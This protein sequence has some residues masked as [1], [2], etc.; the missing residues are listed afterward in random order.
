[1]AMDGQS[2][3]RLD[4][5]R[6]VESLRN[7]VPNRY[8][9]RLL[10][11][12]QP[13]VEERFEALLGALESESQPDHVNGMFVSGGFGTGKSHFLIHLEEAALELGFV[14]SKV[15][16]SKETPLFDLDKVF[17]SAVFHARV[18]GR[19]GLLIENLD[20]PEKLDTAGFE[21]FYGW[22]AT[23]TFRGQL[24]GIF[25]AGLELFV[26]SETSAGLKSRLEAFWGGD[27]LAPTQVKRGL[28]QIGRGQA[29]AFRAPRIA[30]LPPQRLRFL[31]RMIT[32]AGYRGWLVLLDELELIE[33][34]TPLQRGRAYA[35]LTRWFGAG[36]SSSN[37]G[38]VV[39][40]AVSD[41]FVY[42]TISPRGMKKDADN[43]PPKL[44][45]KPRYEGMV[46]DVETG[47]ELLQKHCFPL[48]APSVKE[49]QTVMKRLRQL[50]ATA[51]DW[52]PPDA[53]RESHA[54]GEQ[55]KMRYRIRAAINDWDLERLRERDR[56]I[57]VTLA[58]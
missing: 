2:S 46:P 5:R 50:Y 51:Y 13:G 14:C 23:K 3:G 10:G 22:T 8:A 6:A 15:S 43:L 37:F 38:L 55:S 44:A 18:P 24:N 40:G 1:M 33:R 16:I 31:V 27:K 42:T 4:A 49:V 9:V 30:D 54:V 57:D 41:D 7:G 11:C 56:K 19:R 39:V 20:L 58:R 25:Q 32:G 34:Y 52:Q 17:K 21:N 53:T 48:E 29:G 45:A 47:M 35:E 28:R 26:S 12:N 36:S